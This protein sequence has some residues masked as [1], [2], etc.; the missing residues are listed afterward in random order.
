MT[1]DCLKATDPLFKCIINP[2]VY[3]VTTDKIQ[4]GHKSSIMRG[5]LLYYCFTSFNIIQALAKNIGLELY[6]LD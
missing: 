3:H 1:I 5:M 4:P 2:C 6:G